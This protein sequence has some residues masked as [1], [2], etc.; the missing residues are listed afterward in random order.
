MNSRG[1]AHSVASGS[2]SGKL[3]DGSS[4]RGPKQ[5]MVKRVGALA[6][7]FQNPVH[8]GDL[9][10]GEVTRRSKSLHH[11]KSDFMFVL[12]SNLCVCGAHQPSREVSISGCLFRRKRKCFVEQRGGKKEVK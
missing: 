4:K 10:E 3:N 5:L 8:K 12:N 7:L 2:S 9:V 1:G 11:Q 6:E